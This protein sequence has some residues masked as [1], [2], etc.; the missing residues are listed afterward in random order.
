MMKRYLVPGLSIC[1]VGLILL[2]IAGK[3]R[4]S[5]S[6]S[7]IID[8]IA[9]HEHLIT[10]DQFEIL[11]G[12]EE[13]LLIDL[14]TP[15]E[16]NNYHLPGA[17]NLPERELNIKTIQDIFDATGSLI[18]YSGESAIANQVWI[19]VSQM[20]IEDVLVLVDSTMLFDELPRYEFHPDTTRNLII[21]LHI[22]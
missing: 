21:P 8:R 4:F 20:G 16:F 17:V 6:A 19:L 5:L 9:G 10:A 18:L 14:R 2:S 15:E 13:V 3:D 11:K 1:V 7:D 22:R 12:E